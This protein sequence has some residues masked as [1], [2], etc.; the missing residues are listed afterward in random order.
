M[1]AGGVAHDLNNI[2]AGAVGYSD[3]MVRKV[4][5][6]NSLR[7][8]LLEIRESGRRAAAVVAD[9][10]TISRDAASDRHVANLNSI[11]EEYMISAEQQALSRRFNDI[12][13]TIELEPGLKNMSCSQTHIKKTL[14]N[15]VI[16]AAEATQSGA[17]DDQDEKLCH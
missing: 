11:I 9:L 17:G 8:Y 3:L 5:A 4:S 14:M 12:R 2:L 13:F 7:Q 10:L 1:L 15:L 6:D 16:N